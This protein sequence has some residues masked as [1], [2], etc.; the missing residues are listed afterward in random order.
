MPNMKRPEVSEETAAQLDAVFES[1]FGTNASDIPF[2]SKLDMVLN[3]YE[4]IK[5]IDTDTEATD[6]GV[7]AD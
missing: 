3:D 2:R 7:T 5:N 4:S 6:N 1:V